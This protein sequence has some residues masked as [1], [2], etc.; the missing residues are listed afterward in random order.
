M[1]KTFFA[2][3]NPY[4]YPS[5]SVAIRRKGPESKKEVVSIK[6]DVPVE[7]VKSITLKLTKLLNNGEV[8]EADAKNWARDNVH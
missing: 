4:A 3:S 2:Y 7:H 5:G 6:T 8:S 1:A